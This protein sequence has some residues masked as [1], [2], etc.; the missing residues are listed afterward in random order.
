MASEQQTSDVVVVTSNDVAEFTARAAG[1]AP[2]LPA[3]EA[4]DPG[5]QGSDEPNGNTGES[6][7]DDAAANGATSLDDASNDGNAKQPRL[8]ARFGELTQQRNQMREERDRLAR[9]LEELKR[10][11]QAA[12]VQQAQPKETDQAQAEGTDPAGAP[13]APA[14][15]NPDDLPQQPANDA[16]PDPADVVRKWHMRLGVQLLA[17]PDFD[18]VMAAAADVQIP[19]SMTNAIMESEQGPAIA[20]HLAQN[21]DLAKRLAGSRESVMLRELGKLEATLS[22]QADGSTAAP[23]ARASASVTQRRAPPPPPIS[24]IRSARSDPL[25]ALIDENGEFHGTPEEYQ[26]LRRKGKI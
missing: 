10:G 7:H 18:D 24:P 22:A 9:E 25:D 21:K 6:E 14:A 3:I 1:L 12:P 2:A 23:A 26:E 13:A 4:D 5:H 19:Q 8:Q 20:Y 16:E 17:T 11:Q 15:G